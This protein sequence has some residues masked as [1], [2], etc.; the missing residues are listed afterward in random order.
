MS[1]G[2][3]RWARPSLWRLSIVAVLTWLIGSALF[4]PWLNPFM[5]IDVMRRAETG[6]LL[7]MVRHEVALG[8][9]AAQAHY[10]QHG[11]WPQAPRDLYRPD[12]S[13]LLDFE[14]P[15]PLALRFTHGRGFDPDSGLRGTV[16]EFRYVP[17]QQRWECRPGLPAPPR[18][19]LPVD[20]RPQVDGLSVLQ[21]LLL[22]AVLVLSGLLLW[23]LL[24]DPRLRALQRAPG[25][26]RRQALAELPALDWRL[27]VLL[28]RRGALAAAEIHPDD[29][30][31][32]LRWPHLQAADRAR[33]LAHRIGADSTPLI[34]WQLPGHAFEWRLPQ[35]LPLALER[36]LVYLPGQTLPARE[37]VRRLQTQSIG[38]DVLL[39]VSAAA[40]AD[41]ALLAWASDPGHLGAALDQ[42]TQ[43]EW[44]L[45]PQPVDV[46]QA[47]LARQ[48][49][50]TRISPYQ[51]RGGITRPA[52]FFG[53]SELL[54][55]VLNREPG[56]YLL[57]GGRQLGKTS[58]MKAIE[59]RFDGHP[60]VACHYVSLRDHRLLP[61]LAHLA[62]QPAD[63]PLDA[64]L[65]ALKRVSGERRLLL[66]ID[67][68]DLFLREEARSGYAQLAAL[69]AQSEEGRCHFVLAGF[70]DLYEAIALD[71]ASPI[72]N[73]GE[74]IRLG[75]LER[76]ACLELATQPMKRLGLGYAQP[77]LPA[78]IVEA[79][80]QRANLIAIV[81]QYLLERLGRGERSFDV[82]AVD[83]ALASEAVQ[84]ALAGWSRLSPEPQACALDRALV[85]RIAGND[86]A[87]ADGV[88]MADWLAELDAAGV[89]AA[90][91]SVRRSFARLQ[92]AYVVVR[93]DGERDM[94]DAQAPE[95]GSYRFAV[96]LQVR[97][98]QP[99]EIDALLPRELAGLRPAP[100]IP[101]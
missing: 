16:L 6:A 27:R 69:R 46:L 93:T 33:L 90:P 18:S 98:F 95:L 9:Q 25:R 10:Q 24:F 79:C 37:L 45:H 41:A 59:R 15:E 20:C 80:G 36:V 91:E 28:R 47:V 63:A 1:R 43:S 78:R 29:W 97:Q 86:L 21:W 67:E 94:G 82:A 88:R 22:G 54:A 61:R 84:D 74:V 3:F 62:Q 2:R 92:L 8:V 96:P 14:I 7:G 39:V 32:A 23:L 42:S 60:Q 64:V 48:L 53:R 56:N 19:A 83:A 100:S 31:E 77:A 44:L 66:L 26:L 81:C 11:E 101:K 13:G 73:F 49:R 50:V 89:A 57:V 68:C 75:A 38:Q 51:T 12:S 5:G 4:A 99:D 17:E 65:G 58:L 71:F 85:Y 70:W 30:R 40:R 76:D 72:R 34:D 87:R 35:S 55:R 52:G